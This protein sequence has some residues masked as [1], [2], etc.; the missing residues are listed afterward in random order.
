MKTY[1]FHLLFLTLLLSGCHSEPKDFTLSFTLE[2]L[3]IYKL[4]IEINPDKSYHIQQQNLYLDTHANTQQINTSQGLM[5]DE[6][7]DELKEL[8]AGSHLFKLK[9]SYGFDKE[10]DENNPF[11]NLTYQLTYTQGRKVK[12]ITQRPNTTDQFPA[13]Y[14]ELIQFLIRYSSK[15][16]QTMETPA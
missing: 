16:N 10:P 1:P 11:A 7:Y 14:I 6:E 3:E 4:S 2:S 13:K 12:Y 5:T 15:I 8:I 9:D